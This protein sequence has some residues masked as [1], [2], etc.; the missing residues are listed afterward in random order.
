MIAVAVERFLAVCFPH[1]YHN[2]SAA[3]NYRLEIKKIDINKYEINSNNVKT[4]FKFCT[5]A[6]LVTYNELKTV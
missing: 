5:F 2:M 3:N 1:S 4:A 6:H